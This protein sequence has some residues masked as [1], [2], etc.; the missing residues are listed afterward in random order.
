MLTPRSGATLLELLVAFTVASVALGATV[1]LAVRQQ[2]FHG[3]LLAAL[4]H[5]DQVGQTAALVPVE[6]RGLAPGEDD[7]AEA[8][9]TAVQFRATIA[10]AIACDTAGGVLLAPPDRTPPVGSQLDTPREG[11]SL[12]YPVVEDSTERWEA[13]VVTAVSTASGICR[14]GG[15]EIFAGAWSGQRL[16]L[17][18]R[19]AIVPGIPV[20]VTR[21]SRYS[22][23]R[24][25]DGAWY[26]GFRDWNH[27][28]GR[29]N[30]IQPV[31]GPFRP[32]GA[33]GL[34]FA[35]FD[36]NGAQV[37]PDAA[38]RRRIARIEVTVATDA[39]V[40]A[41]WSQLRAA[42]E[43]RATVALRNRSRE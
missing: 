34:R 11:D 2:R 1:Q 30:T 26:L 31:S 40:G 18:H 28:L 5:G 6:L 16:S 8:R 38:G 14:V 43:S 25:G 39:G 10:S 21:W 29:F 7:I 22:V 35:Y 41:P 23:Y 37:A 42:S 13:R 20:R 24:A 32:P 3:E 27:T 15:V 4:A 33:A 36:M 17:D 9:D 12:W 19:P